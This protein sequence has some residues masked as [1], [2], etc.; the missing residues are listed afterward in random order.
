M[1]VILTQSCGSVGKLNNSPKKIPAYTLDTDTRSELLQ[2][3]KMELPSDTTKTIIVY[4]V[5]EDNKKSKISDETI[6]LLIADFFGTLTTVIT[7]W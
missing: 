7:L 6:R 4:N 5:V 2:S 3:D 1:F